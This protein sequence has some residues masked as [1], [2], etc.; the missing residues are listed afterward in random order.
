LFDPTFG[1]FVYSRPVYDREGYILSMIDLRNNPEAGYTQQITDNPWTG[2]YSPSDKNCGVKPLK[3]DYLNSYGSDFNQYWR[4]EIKSAYPV[5]YG[6]KSLYK[7]I[8]SIRTII[9]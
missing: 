1:I 7:Y 5:I 8:Y 4:T 3:K 9:F 6:G 2:E